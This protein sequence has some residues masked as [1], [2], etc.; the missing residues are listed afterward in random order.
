MQNTIYM[1]EQRRQFIYER[2][3]NLQIEIHIL[4]LI[5]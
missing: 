5:C 1:V 3:V 2:F 4:T